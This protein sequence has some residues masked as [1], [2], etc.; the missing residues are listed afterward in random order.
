MTAAA[1][2]TTRGTPMTLAWLIEEKHEPGKNFC[3][4]QQRRKTTQV[5]GQFLLSSASLAQLSSSTYKINNLA[6][7]TFKS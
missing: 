6:V 7:L 5:T 4:Q 2:A 3:Q 1:G